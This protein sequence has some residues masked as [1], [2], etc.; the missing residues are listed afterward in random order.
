MRYLYLLL[1]IS[2]FYSCKDRSFAHGE[3]RE[4]IVQH[5]GLGH[6]AGERIHALVVRGAAERGHA[7]GLRFTARE[8]RG[9]VGAGQNAGLDFNG[10]HGLGVASVDAGAF[11][12]DALA[13][14]LLFDVA[15]DVA[16]GGEGLLA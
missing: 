11:V 4:V 3:G 12:K 6:V 1:T 14:D 5:E 15:D 10:A 9:A 13:H 7:Q 8:Q 2:C 16:D